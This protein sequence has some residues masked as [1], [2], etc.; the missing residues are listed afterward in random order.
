MSGNLS[1]VKQAVIEAA[2]VPSGLLHRARERFGRRVTTLAVVL[3]I[4]LFILVM[5]VIEGDVPELLRSL[6][7]YM[8]AIFVRLGGLAPFGLL[9]AE[10]SGVPMPIPGDV[11]VMWVGHHAPAKLLAWTAA[12]LGLIAAVVLGSSNLYL[13]ASKWGRSLVDHHLGRTLHLSPRRM[14]RAEAWFA[15]WGPWALIFGRHIPGFRVPLTIAAGIFKV[16]YFVFALS[17]AVS[18]AVWTA[19]FLFVG[20]TLGGR[21]QHLFAIHR[22]TV[23]LIVILVV[24]SGIVYFV[25]RGLVLARKKTGLPRS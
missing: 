21:M 18:T 11:F 15:R 19:V 16:R 6:R 23:I 10:E 24:V 13:L 4:G 2:Q 25:S 14:A 9:Y 17:V 20:I 5:A 7:P 12:W 3:L 22:K 1:G 8:R